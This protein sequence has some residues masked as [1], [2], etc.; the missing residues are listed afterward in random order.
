MHKKYEVIQE[1]NSDCGIACLASII[2][3]YKG[4]IPLEILRY[5]TM[6]DNNGTNA[7]NLITYAKKIGFN[8]FGKK[9][10]SITDINNI[11]LPVIAHIKL[12]NNLFHFV[13]IYE[14]NNSNIILMD[15]S[16]GFKKI[17]LIEFN[18]LFTGVI[19]CFKPINTIPILNGNKFL[20]KTIN[21]Y[22]RDNKYITI[23]LII[24]NIFILLFTLVENY[25]IK[26]LNVS[27]KYF[28][29]LLIIII[30]NQLF[31]YIKNI[32]VL[33]KSIDFNNKLIS[34]FIKHI[35][36]LPLKYLKLKQKGEITLRFSELNELSNNILNIIVNVILD[37]ILVII[38]INLLFIYF[39]PLSFFVILL[40]ILYLV[41]NIIIYKKLYNLIK[42]SI[43]MEE[44]YNSNIIDLITKFTTI[45][46][47]SN[48]NY[49]FNN[50][51]NNLNNKNVIQKSINK[52]IFKIDFI[53]NTII[54]IFILILLYFLLNN[55]YSLSNSILIIIIINYYISTLK[56]II[57]YYPSMILIKNIIIKNNEFLSFQSKKKTLALTYFNNIKIKKLNY[58]INN[59]RIINNLTYTINSKDKIF[60]NGP[61]GIGKSTLLKIIN[62]EIDDYS[63][64]VSINDTDIKKYDLSNMLSYT[65]QDEDL[66]NDTIINNLT[67][68]KNIDE[69]LLNR[70]IKITRLKEI[71]VIKE[72]GLNSLVIN[73][74]SFSGGEKNRIILA[75]SLIHS[76]SLIILDEVL[77]E[78]DYEMEKVIVSEMI[79]YFYDRTIIY[80]SH[81]DV[82]NLFDKVLTFRKE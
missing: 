60:I 11:D 33:N 81:K 78:V 8:S 29:I 9:I 27:N 23:I 7:Y 73:S 3:Y 28:Y 63:G 44:N 18:K 15:P 59:N 67:M 79:E 76:K 80:V 64:L 49:I 45:K 25:E 77:K 58:S 66:F 46:H 4:Y 38:V 1:E 34:F 14:I 5:N 42:Y 50:I 70:V 22:I 43:N 61:S 55:N 53:N 30:L 57:N 69:D 39:N 47:L 37:L 32:L 74:N 17:E 16:V 21:K 75:R 51:N 20:N 65:S 24:I 35:F 26:L 52:K 19:I 82:S 31:I 56:R 12:E 10:N 2:K 48:Y 72:C 54:N 6:T 40:T 13:V 36:N 68:N 62:N 71:S 41:I